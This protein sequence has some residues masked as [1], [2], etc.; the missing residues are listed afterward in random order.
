MK[1]VGE[2]MSIG[3]TFKEAC[4]RRCGPWRPD[5]SGSGWTPRT[6]LRGQ[7]TARRRSRAH[8]S[9][10]TPE[11][12]FYL[13]DALRAGWSRAKST[14]RPGSTR[15]SSTRSSRSS[16]REDELLACGGL[17]ELSSDLLRDAK[18]DLAS[19]TSR[20][21][22]PS[23]STRGMCA[24]GARRTTS[25]RPTSWWT[26]VRR[27]S[28]RTRRTS[29]RA[30][31]GRTRSG[32]ARR[33]ARRHPRRRPEP[34]RAGHRVRLLLLPRRLRAPGGR[35]RDDHGQLQPGDGLHRLRHLRP[36]VLRAAHRSRT[37]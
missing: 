11:R 7:Q 2:A 15:G 13:R 21:R 22:S 12:I 35:V 34:D 31:S 28:R 25:G 24:R 33:P 32:S 17:E 4:R 26:P 14:R 9:A 3:R 29:T 6:R 19:P 1:S 16:R 18:R 27:S 30:T 10:P 5:A 23:E 37:C 8:L 20:W 36:A